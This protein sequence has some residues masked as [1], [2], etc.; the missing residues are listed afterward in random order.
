MKTLRNASADAIGQIRG[1]GQAIAE[2]VFGFF[3]EPKNRKLLE[4]LEKLGLNFDE[5]MTA[6]G[7]RRAGDRSRVRPT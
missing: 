5:P 6:G 2:A 3:D 4:R 1:V 7:G